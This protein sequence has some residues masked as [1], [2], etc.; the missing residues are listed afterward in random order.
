MAQ[1]FGAVRVAGQAFRHRA[2]RWLCGSSI[3]PIAVNFP[4]DL[5]L[6]CFARTLRQRRSAM[7]KT[8]LILAPLSMLALAACNN[9]ETP[10]ADAEAEA[11]KTAAA[12][13]P[14]EMPPAITASGTYRCGDNSILY[15]DFL[16]ENEA[17]D[18]RVGDRAAAAIRVTAPEVEAPADGAAPAP[19]AEAAPAGPMKSADG[20]SSLSGSGKQIN[21][22]LADK[23]AQTCKSS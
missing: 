13:A 2:S 8:L 22:K 5:I 20:N 9:S 17:A 7:K 18:I 23:G 14:V 19:A 10:A 21:V 11:A 4:F 6:L 12:A 3:S 1:S 16:G 15:V